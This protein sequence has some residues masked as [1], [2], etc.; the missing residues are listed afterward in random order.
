MNYEQLLDKFIKQERENCRMGS[1]DDMWYEQQVIDYI[2][3]QRPVWI[4]FIWRQI[5]F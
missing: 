5:F 3:K 2:D 1:G 4:E